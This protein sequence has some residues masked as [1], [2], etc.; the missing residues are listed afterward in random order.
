MLLKKLFSTLLWNT[1]C[2][3]E[4]QSLSQTITKKLLCYSKNLSPFRNAMGF[5]AHSVKDISR[6]VTHLLSFCRPSTIQRRIVFIAVNTIK[7]VFWTWTFTY[8]VSKVLEGVQPTVAYLNSPA[9]IVFV[10]IVMGIVTA[11]LHPSPFSVHHSFRETVGLRCFR[12][13]FSLK[14]ATAFRV[15]CLQIV[16]SCRGLAAALTLAYGSLSFKTKD[17]QTTKNHSNVCVHTWRITQ[18][19][20]LRQ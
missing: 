18:M 4:E 10:L 13:T 15:T 17:S 19:T 1:Q 8:I 5:F 3:F 12:G 16:Q 6:C 2:F 11:S 7:T 20:Y 9:A 14:A